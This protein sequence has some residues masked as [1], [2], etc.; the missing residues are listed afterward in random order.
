MH[1]TYA[2]NN[3]N[4]PSNRRNCW[5]WPSDTITVL[6]TFHLPLSAATVEASAATVGCAS[7]LRVMVMIRQGTR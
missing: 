2:N 7:A 3:N 5:V 1:T 6:I 4:M